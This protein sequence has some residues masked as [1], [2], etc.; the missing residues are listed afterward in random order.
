M[1]RVWLWIGAGLIACFLMTKYS[2]PIGRLIPKIETGVY[3]WRMMTLTSFAMAMLAGALFEVWSKRGD[4]S[5]LPQVL[6]DGAWLPP[7][8]SLTVLIGAVA[9]SAWYVAWPMV[10][11]QSFEPNFEHYNYAT[12]PRGVPREAPPMDQTRLASGS[13]RV[14]VE[15]W[16]PELRRLRVE[17][18]KP[19]QLQF[20]A[21]NFAGWTATVDGGFVEIKEGSVK[22]IVID[23]PAGAH[24]VNLE[25]RSTPVRR[26][27]NAITILSLAI[28]FT[29]LGV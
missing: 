15:Y 8:A 21:S 20:R 2:E 26:V 17:A 18:E 10:R 6:K 22:N 1:N 23:L 3:S 14:T 24:T 16:A 27:A 13:G 7:L 28:L 19:D 9:M 25:L 12:L 4:S 11:G 5:I 29:M